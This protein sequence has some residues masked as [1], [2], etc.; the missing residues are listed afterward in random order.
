[1]HG[2][3][4]A[5]IRSARAPSRGHRRDGRLHDA[6][7]RAAPAA[8]RRADDA[9]LGIGEQDRRAIGGEHAERDARHGGHHAVGARVFLAPPGRSTVIAAV[10]W[11]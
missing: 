1:M 10:P 9:R 2:P 5:R 6:G 4:P 7:Q 11:T 3:M 8:M